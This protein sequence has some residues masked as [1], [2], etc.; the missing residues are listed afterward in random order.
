MSEMFEL[1]CS[2]VIIRVTRD[3]RVIVDLFER[4]TEGS[5]VWNDEA[6]GHD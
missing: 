5:G 4:D 1:F 3:N 6:R 2:E